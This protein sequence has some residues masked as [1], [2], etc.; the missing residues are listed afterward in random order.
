MEIYL[1]H[2]TSNIKPLVLLPINEI[3]KRALHSLEHASRF[4]LRPM[5]GMLNPCF[6]AANDP[7]FISPVVVG[8]HVFHVRSGNLLFFARV[9]AAGRADTYRA[10]RSRRCS[11][12][13][14]DADV[15]A[16][17]VCER[18]VIDRRTTRVR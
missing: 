16:T 13:S 5:E 9:C 6:D 17:F 14:D 12:D 1:A 2:Q 10:D 18:S 4:F 3:R 7:L 15:L 11:Y 8:F